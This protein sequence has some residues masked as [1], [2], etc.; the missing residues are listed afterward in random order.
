LLFLI[1][2]FFITDAGSTGIGANDTTAPCDNETLGQTSGTANIEVDWVPNTINI[3]W[4][5]DNK[6]IT[7]QNNAQSCV[8]GN[9]LYLPTAPTKTGYTFK[10]WTV[11][12]ILPEGCTQIA[13]LQ[14]N[15][16]QWIDTGLSFN[17]GTIKVQANVYTDINFGNSTEFDFLGNVDNL[18]PGRP[19]FCIGMWN[20]NQLFLYGYPNSDGLRPTI[21]Q[22][23]WYTLD[24]EFVGNTASFWVDGTLANSVANRSPYS[25]NNIVLFNGGPGYIYPASSHQKINTVSIYIDN[26]LVRD[27]VPIKDPDGVPCMYDKVSGDFFYN[28]GTGNFTAGPIVLPE[29]YTKLEYIESTGTQWIDTKLRQ[30]TSLTDIETYAGFAYSVLPTRGN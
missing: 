17:S 22:S 9:D 20:S 8:Y 7:V 19:G 5:N 24:A 26:V 3:R 10:G 13:Y 30:N 29:G 14:S 25:S 21:S 28:A 15:G 11:A 4:Y 12:D 27:F 6:Q 18:K 2:I 1:A 23:G 16:S